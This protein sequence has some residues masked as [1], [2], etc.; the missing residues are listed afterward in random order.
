MF[1]PAALFELNE[2]P[3]EVFMAPQAENF[4]DLR[5]FS[6]YPLVSPGSE[7]RGVI[8]QG[9]RLIVIKFDIIC[10]LSPSSQLRGFQIVKMT[11]VTLPK[12]TYV[13]LRP[14]KTAFIEVNRSFYYP[15]VLS[16]MHTLITGAQR[17]HRLCT[18][19][20]SLCTAV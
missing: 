5:G 20:R 2:H 18:T 10:R 16:V 13:K 7:T 15:P 14:H 3:N 11:N 8:T 6:Y 9:Y 19:V 4:V 1:S 17:L 12:G